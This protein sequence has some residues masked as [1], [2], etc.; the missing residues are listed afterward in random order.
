MDFNIQ[1]THK[2]K[3]RACNIYIDS[4]AYPCYIFVILTDKDL[5][6]KFGDE[7]TIKTDCEKRLPKKDDYLEL[8]ELRESIFNVVKAMPEF[9]AVKKSMVSLRQ[10]QTS[11]LGQLSYN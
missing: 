11:P 1:F 7:I 4:T 6:K 5:I 8:V 3:S 2:N 9:M 10:P